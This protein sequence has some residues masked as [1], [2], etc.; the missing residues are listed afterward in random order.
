MKFQNSRSWEIWRGSNCAE[1]HWLHCT[2]RRVTV[3]TFVLAL[4]GSTGRECFHN[5]R[6]AALHVTAKKC[7]LYYVVPQILLTHL[8]VAR[9]S[10]IS[11]RSANAN[12][13]QKAL[14]WRVRMLGK[15]L[16]YQLRSTITCV[17]H[18]QRK[19]IPR[20]GSK[21]LENL[22]KW[23]PF[24]HASNIS[25]VFLQCRWCWADSPMRTGTYGNRVTGELSRE[26]TVLGL[27]DHDIR[28]RCQYR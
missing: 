16:R 20:F 3:S 13:A 4:A 26:Q 9:F 14:R 11:S 23:C 24:L 21:D 18:W 25:P 5:G 28:I 2:L 17:K 7:K 10:Q 12:R 27:S 22:G 19:K 6:T 1:V 8:E 15:A